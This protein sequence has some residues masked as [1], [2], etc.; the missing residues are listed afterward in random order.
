AAAIALIESGVE[1]DAVTPTDSTSALLMA[2]INGQFDVAIELVKR[3]ANVNLQST[4][5]ATALY[6]TINTQWAPKSRFPQ[7]Q[8]IQNQKTTYL[9]LMD[10][11]IAHKADPNVRVRQNLWY[12]AFNNCG[13]S[14]CGLEQI[15]GSNAFWR[16][17]YSVDVE[18]MK[19]LV[20]AGA[21]Y[22]VPTQRMAAPAAAGGRGGR[23]G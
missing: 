23:G 19:K 16:A 13:N 8:A 17:A 6:A 10:S 21:D 12:F 1:I 15:E 5:G 9:E 14:N 7:P 22:K 3:G 2:A 4:G 11:L 20:A 18:A